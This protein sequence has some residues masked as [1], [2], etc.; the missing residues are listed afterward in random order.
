MVSKRLAHMPHVS[1]FSFS[2]YFF[3]NSPPFIPFSV[4][5]VFITIPTPCISMPVPYFYNTFTHP[6]LLSHLYSHQSLFQT[7]LSSFLSL[8]L[9]APFPTLLLNLLLIL[10]LLCL[11]HTATTPLSME[12]GLC[13]FPPLKPFPDSSSKKSSSCTNNSILNYQRILDTLKVVNYR[14]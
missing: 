8:C 3:F 11:P 7:L 4:H 12:K 6:Q 13:F 9:A 1:Y 2:I 5:L 14:A 10:P